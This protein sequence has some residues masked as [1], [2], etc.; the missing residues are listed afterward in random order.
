MRFLIAGIILIRLTAS[1]P[2]AAETLPE[3]TALMNSAAGAIERAIAASK[4][5]RVSAQKELK[6]VAKSIPPRIEVE[7]ERGKVD[8]DLTWLRIDLNRLSGYSGSNLRQELTPVLAQVRAI[9]SMNLYRHDASNVDDQKAE[10]TLKKVLARREYQPSDTQRF[11]DRI[12]RIL[13]NA[14]D[15][16][17]VPSQAA[18]VIGYVVLTLVVIAF[19]VLLAVVAL[20]LANKLTQNRDKPKTR[21]QRVKIINEAPS[22]QSVLSQAE[23]DAASGN[24]RE[25]FRG[26]YLASILLLDRAGLVGYKEDITNWEYVRTLDKKSRPDAADVF[27]PLTLAFD[28]L[29]YGKRGVTRADYGKSLDYYRS[30]E[31]I[32]L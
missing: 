29:I 4:T 23:Q 16:L 28:E 31:E 15:K 12:S 10:T 20:R 5:D 25:G 26:V 14:L 2:V 9:S 27:K 30:L 18:A 11:W 7:S 13:F 1:L 17:H 8:V 24:F 3:Y 6:A 32:L 19:A 22:V 21:R